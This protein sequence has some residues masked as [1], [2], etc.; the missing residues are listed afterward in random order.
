MFVKILSETLFSLWFSKSMGLE[1]DNP[2]FWN[3]ISCWSNHEAQE[4]SRFWLASFFHCVWLTCI[5]LI[6]IQT[7]W[8]GFQLSAHDLEMVT[9]WDSVS[10]SVE[11]SQSTH[12]ERLCLWHARDIS[13]QSELA[14][15]LSE[16][17]LLL[18]TQQSS[19]LRPC[20]A[21]CLQGATRS[22]QIVSSGS[23]A[24]HWASTFFQCVMLLSSPF[25]LQTTLLLFK[26]REHI[27]SQGHFHLHTELIPGMSCG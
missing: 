1:L 14:V 21:S 12:E 27:S 13:V 16:G 7:L 24:Y 18:P 23:S 25:C 22:L 6:W 19:C 9:S 3:L 15:C 17:P 11:S 26:H 2:G 4:E 10:S 20:F 8:V 5:H